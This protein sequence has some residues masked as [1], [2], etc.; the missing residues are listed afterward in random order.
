MSIY[1]E[2]LYDWEG[3]GRN[4]A[5]R[6]IQQLKMSDWEVRDARGRALTPA[7]TPEH[8]APALASS[9]TLSKFDQERQGARPLILSFRL[10]QVQRHIGTASCPLVQLESA[11]GSNV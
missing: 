4:P 11:G 3:H 1:G 10:R 5:D 9:Y 7:P 6:T 2:G 8:T